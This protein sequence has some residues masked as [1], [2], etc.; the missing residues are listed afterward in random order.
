MNKFFLA[1]A[2][3]CALSIQSFAEEATKGSVAVAPFVCDQ[4]SIV[5]VGAKFVKAKDKYSYTEPLIYLSDMADQSKTSPSYTL[6][7]GSQK[8][9][10]KLN[11]DGIFTCTKASVAQGCKA[12]VAEII[13]GPNSGVDTFK[14]VDKSGKEF[15]CRLEKSTFELIHTNRFN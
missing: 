1:L 9:A 4:Y 6:T 15:P 8:E 13:N 5:F 2:L 10:D 14:V 3:L 7:K 11:V 12:R